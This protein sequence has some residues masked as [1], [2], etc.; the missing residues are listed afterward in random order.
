LS[1]SPGDMHVEDNEEFSI[2]YRGEQV[3]EYE[4]HTTVDQTALLLRSLNEFVQNPGMYSL[5]G[6]N[7]TSVAIICLNK[8]KFNIW[9]PPYCNFPSDL[10]KV[11]NSDKSKNIVKNKKIF[12]IK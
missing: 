8:A 12:T 11:L 3:T 9:I 7:C 1:G 2:S 10:S 5:T 6:Y 4:L